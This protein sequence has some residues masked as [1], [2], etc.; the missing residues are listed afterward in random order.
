TQHY[1][2]SRWPPH[3]K[4]SPRTPLPGTRSPGEQLHTIQS[5]LPRKQVTDVGSYDRPPPAPAAP[6]KELEVRLASTLPV[7]QSGCEKQVL[8]ARPDVRPRWMMGRRP[9]PC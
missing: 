5:L 8:Y 3:S 1:Q 9:S 6:V 4:V 2:A 7:L